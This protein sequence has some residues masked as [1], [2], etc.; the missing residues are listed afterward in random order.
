MQNMYPE[1]VPG[2]THPSSAGLI[3]RPSMELLHSG[4]SSSPLLSS[5]SQDHACS[6]ILVQPTCGYVNRIGTPG[7]RF[8]ASKTPPCFTVQIQRT[9]SSNVRRCWPNSR[10]AHHSADS[11]IWTPVLSEF[12]VR[13]H[14][15]DPLLL[16]N[17]SA[18]TAPQSLLHGTCISSSHRLRYVNA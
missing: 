10:M 14:S 5:V 8:P 12:G 18:I 6:D 13:N 9:R 16:A 11:D 17:V 2:K 7:S 1:P 3:G 4:S 15:S